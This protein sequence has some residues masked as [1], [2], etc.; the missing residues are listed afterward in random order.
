V[1][2]GPIPEIWPWEPAGLAPRFRSIADS[3]CYLIAWPG[4]L[5]NLVDGDVLTNESTTAY[6]AST[7]YGTAWNFTSTGTARKA[8]ISTNLPLVTS[9]GAGTGDF[10]MFGVGTTGLGASSGAGCF[11]TYGGTVVG[12]SVGSTVDGLWHAWGG[13]RTGTVLELFRDGDSLGTSSFTVQDILAGSQDFVVGGCGGSTTL[14]GHHGPIPIAAAWNRALEDSEFALLADDPLGLIRYE[15]QIV[16][17]RSPISATI[18]GTCVPTITETDVTT[19]G[20]TVIITLSG[21]T[22]KAAGTGPIGTIAQSEALIDGISAAS[23]PAGGWN[24]EVRDNVTV[25]TDLVRTSDTVAT[26]TLAAEAGY[27]ISSTE[28]ISVVVPTDALT[29]GAGAINGDVT[30][31]VTAVAAGLGIPIAAYH[32]NHH[33]GSMAS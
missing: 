7:P 19:G 11:M 17:A 9:D 31:T 26:W 27:D 6:T 3:I 5:P 21:D 2:L 23:S 8:I 32:Y 28:T 13:K 12:V 20:K 29:T 25:G 16:Y 24:A 4:P 1:P 30:F 33:L 14:Y 10:S 18:T 22:W 15:P